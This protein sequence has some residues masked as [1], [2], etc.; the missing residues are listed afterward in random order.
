VVKE[1]EAEN[2]FATAKTNG[3]IDGLVEEQAKS[4]AQFVEPLLKYVINVH[5]HIKQL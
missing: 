3:L 2:E 5:G 1:R 4:L